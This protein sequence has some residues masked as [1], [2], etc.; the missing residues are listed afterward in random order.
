MKDTTLDCMQ[1]PSTSIVWR[2]SLTSL[3]A[4]SCYGRSFP[5]SPFALVRSSPIKPMVYMGMPRP[6]RTYPHLRNIPCSNEPS[7]LVAQRFASSG[8]F[9]SPSLPQGLGSHQPFVK[10]P[11]AGDIRPFFT[12]QDNDH[13]QL[14]NRLPPKAGLILGV[15]NPFFE[16]SC[17]HWPHVLSLGRSARYVPISFRV[18]LN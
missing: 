16:K 2:S 7:D 14:V 18:A 6:L 13:A 9:T 8:T 11:L 15:T 3:S 5:A 4:D 17:A 12:M 10:I 1:V